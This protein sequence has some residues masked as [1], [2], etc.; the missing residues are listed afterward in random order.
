MGGGVGGG[1][2]ES[3]IPLVPLFCL[4]LLPPLRLQ[5]PP[6]SLVSLTSAKTSSVAG[7]PMMGSA[8][9]FI[10]VLVL[11]DKIG[12]SV[13]WLLLVVFVRCLLLRSAW[14]LVGDGTTFVLWLSPLRTDNGR[15][16]REDDLSCNRTSRGGSLVCW[17]DLLVAKDLRL[18]P[19]PRRSSKKFRGGILLGLVRR[20]MQ[21]GCVGLCNVDGLRVVGLGLS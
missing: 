1:D 7:L 19:P 20:M 11:D 5:L 2:G 18:L 6:R 16:F 21:L 14:L 15:L 13:S 9:D 4:L 3:S 8:V 12:K 17:D 10:G